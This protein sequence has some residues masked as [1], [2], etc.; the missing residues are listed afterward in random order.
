MNTKLLLGAGVLGLALTLSARALCDL[1]PV[2]SDAP[3]IDATRWYNHIGRN[4][5]LNAL[6]G[7]AVLLEF[8]ATW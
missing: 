1:P 7:Q 6:R 4:P 3:E 8:W 5:D 2:G